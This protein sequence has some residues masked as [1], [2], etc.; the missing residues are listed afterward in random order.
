MYEPMP[1]HFTPKKS[2]KNL[3]MIVIVQMN[4]IVM[5]VIYLKCMQLVND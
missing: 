3:F 4:N 5:R 1:Y 2:N